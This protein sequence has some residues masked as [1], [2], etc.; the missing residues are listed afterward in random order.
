MYICDIEYNISIRKFQT[1]QFNGLK[2]IFC[3]NMSILIYIM[4]KTPYICKGC[5]KGFKQ[6]RILIVNSVL[7]SYKSYNRYNK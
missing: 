7:R 5:G 3:Y 4:I 6:C 2:V 1:S